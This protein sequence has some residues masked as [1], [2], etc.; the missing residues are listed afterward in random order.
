MSDIEPL[1]S[2]D[3]ESRLFE[4][5]DQNKIKFHQ[6]STNTSMQQKNNNR[7]INNKKDLSSTTTTTT[8]TTTHEPTMNSVELYSTTYVSASNKKTTTVSK[9][10]VMDDNAFDVFDNDSLGLLSDSDK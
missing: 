10:D 6:S 1:D 2:T 3:D 4:S 8:T 9:T 7:S 5:F